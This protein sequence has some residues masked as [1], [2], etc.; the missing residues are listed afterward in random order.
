VIPTI[1]ALATAPGRAGVAIMRVSGPDTRR[2]IATLTGKDVPQPRLATLRA[3]VH[4]GRHIDRGLVLFFAA[5]ASF[6]GEDMAEFQIHGGR[7]VAARLARALETLGAAPAAPG[8]FTRRA[9][10]NGKLDLTQAEAIADLAAAET[11]AQAA[12]ALDQAN[13]GLLTLYEGWRAR[14]V[15]ALA[16]MEASLDFPEEDLPDTLLAPVAAEAAALAEEVSLHLA[17]ARRGA[18]LRDGIA[19]AVLGAP[20][21]G[22]SS[23]V[24]VLAARAAAIVSPLPGTTRDVIEVPLDL[25]GYPVIL[26]DTAGLRDSADPIEA[27]GI[28]RARA[29]A[30]DADI[31]LLV[32]DATVPPDGETLALV[33]EKA[34]VVQNKSDIVSPHALPPAGEGP[35]EGPGEGNVIVISTLTGDGIAPLLEALTEKLRA[36]AGDQVR[37]APTRERHRI[38]LIEADAALRAYPLAPTPDLAAEE[39]RR[40]ANALGRLTGRIDSEELLDRIFKDFCIGK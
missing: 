26:I 15:A 6:T 21:A 30:A 36:L 14:L 13:G 22:K 16:L 23:L 10:E 3:L 38:H 32:F 33:D 34:L 17:D 2:V 7:A 12:Q 19:I 11:E 40:A 5:P 29:R 25:G 27:E 8:A 35:G 9:F 20:N 24:N 18:R 37:P 39:L 4:E 1:F 31:K 28:A